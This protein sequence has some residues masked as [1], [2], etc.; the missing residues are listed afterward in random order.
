MR[1][2]DVLIGCMLMLT[3]WV[4]AEETPSLRLCANGD[5]T[6]YSAFADALK[7]ANRAPEA[8]MTLLGDVTFEGAARAQSIRTNLTT[9]LNTTSLSMRPLRGRVIIRH[10]TPY[11][12][13][14][15]GRM[16]TILGVP[17]KK[18]D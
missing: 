9:D 16:Y 14:P 10:N 18:E 2:A 11:I 12:L 13:L 1:H 6:Y 7:I 3:S 4:M 8:Q 17:A 5:T 15:D